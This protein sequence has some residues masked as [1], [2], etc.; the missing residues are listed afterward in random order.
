MIAYAQPDDQIAVSTGYGIEAARPVEQLGFAAL[1]GSSI[2]PVWTEVIDE[3]LAV[4][5]LRDD[6]DDQGSRAPARALVDRAI[7]LAQRLRTCGIEAPH[8][9]VAGVNGTV[10][11][12]WHEYDGYREIE[13]SS[14][15][16]AEYTLIRKGSKTV[17]KSF[18]FSLPLR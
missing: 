16:R 1:D 7:G 11:L 9:A 18:A 8:R 10:V 2:D 12:E 14:P 13:V 3:L 5:S 15:D 6:W 4:R 17:D